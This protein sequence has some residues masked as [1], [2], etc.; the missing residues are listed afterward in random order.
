M[1]NFIKRNE[2]NYRLIQQSRLL[3]YMQFWKWIND[4]ELLREIGSLGH[5]PEL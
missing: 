5:F 4:N 2:F 3:E 1:L